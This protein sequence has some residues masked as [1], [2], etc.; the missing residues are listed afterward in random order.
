MP[1]VFSVVPVNYFTKPLA[2]QRSPDSPVFWICVGLHIENFASYKGDN[3]LAYF[4][5]N[6]FDESIL[7]PVA[8]E[9]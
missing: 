5:L 6:D 1:F 3:C 4:D 2:P 8:W 9:L 7:A